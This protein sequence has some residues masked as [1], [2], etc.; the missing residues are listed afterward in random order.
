MFSKLHEAIGRGVIKFF[1]KRE[2]ANFKKDSITVELYRQLG[3]FYLAT[4]LNREYTLPDTLKSGL[5]QRVNILED[6]TLPQVS[7]SQA[8][9][10]RIDSCFKILFFTKYDASVKNEI[11]SI[12][13]LAPLE[14]LLYAA[15]HLRN[16]DDHQDQKEER[17]FYRKH[18]KYMSTLTN[19]DLTKPNV[20]ILRVAIE[21]MR[22]FNAGIDYLRSHALPDGHEK[23]HYPR[24][25]FKEIIGK[26]EVISQR[27]KSEVVSTQRTRAKLEML[28]HTAEKMSQSESLGIR[29]ET[30][31]EEIFDLLDRILFHVLENLMVR[32]RAVAGHD[33]KVRLDCGSA[34]A[35]KVKH[36]FSRNGI[37]VM[38]IA[39]QGRSTLI[40]NKIQTKIDNLRDIRNKI[41][42]PSNAAIK[43][44]DEKS[45]EDNLLKLHEA[46]GRGIVDLFNAFMADR[47][48]IFN[49]S[50]IGEKVYIQL[51]KFFLE[52]E[53]DTQYQIPA[54]LE[55]GLI[56]AFQSKPGF[57][58]PHLEEDAKIAVKGHFKNLFTIGEDKDPEKSNTSNVLVLHP[59][60]AL[61][62]AASFLQSKVTTIIIKDYI[63]DF[64]R[65]EHKIFNSPGEL[66]KAAD[67]FA[68]MY[69]VHLREVRSCLS[70][71][72]FPE[73]HPK[74]MGVEKSFTLLLGESAPS[75]PPKSKGARRAKAAGAQFSVGAQRRSL[76]Q[77]SGDSSKSSSGNCNVKYPQLRK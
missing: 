70:V 29:A 65:D 10:C 54:E 63:G 18:L 22:N 68:N 75:V 21:I 51:G 67:A 74:L 71:Y 37:E 31:D 61:C 69:Y 1:E 44:L 76:A 62:Y 50:M 42:N 13:A 41:I 5:I 11:Q 35:E 77:S 45:I 8:Q 14:I 9:A 24:L 7:L 4:P 39:A 40:I 55:R 2:K 30:L 53:V 59:L 20:E 15:T 23:T 25:F 49:E 33:A 72:G 73:D 57:Y 38:M 6:Q 26:V 32:W 34:D 12:A 60:H 3:E 16:E 17:N 47:D 19:A 27:S 28:S 58:S 43:N 46:I 36:F 64:R 52:T 48:Y 66:M 56:A